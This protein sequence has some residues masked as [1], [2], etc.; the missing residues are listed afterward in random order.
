[1]LEAARAKLKE[2]IDVVVGVVETHG[3]EETKAL[4]AGFEILPRL[5]ISY[6]NREYTEFDIDAALKRAPHLLLVDEMAH[7]NIPG[8]R[9]EKRWQDIKELLDRGINVYTTLNVQHVESVNDIVAQITGTIVRETVPDSMLQLADT[10]ELV[11]LAPED[12]LQRLQEG[13]VYFPEQA[14]FALQ[15]FFKTSNLT[16]LREL[17][18]RM[19][20]ERV[21]QQMLSQRRLTATDK[22][23]ATSDRLLVIIGKEHCEQT[24]HST[25]ESMLI[26]KFC[27]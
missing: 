1:M 22:P 21:N 9:H 6:Q 18:L 4:V 12:L 8:S 17:A 10:V 14:E 26:W 16:A 2:K 25:L 23:W 7:T 27:Q 11:D 24:F 13:K 19:T 15:N 3:R 5:T 20:A